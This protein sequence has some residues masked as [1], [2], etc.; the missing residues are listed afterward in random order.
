MSGGVSRDF[1]SSNGIAIS[2]LVQALLNFDLFRGSP[3][4]DGDGSIG[5][6]NGERMPPAHAHTCM[7]MDTCAHA[8]DIIGNSQVFPQWGWPFA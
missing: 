5:I 1:K 2:Q 3:L 6:G 8:Y 7:H 4:G